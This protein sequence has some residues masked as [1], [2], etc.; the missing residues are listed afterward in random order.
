M[1]KSHLPKGLKG[2]N[3][4]TLILPVKKKIRRIENGDKRKTEFYF[5]SLKTFS[6]DL[7]LLVLPIGGFP[8][9]NGALWL[10]TVSKSLTPL[11]FHLFAQDLALT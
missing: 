6:P 11:R 2:L 1:I 5:S 10:S 7:V 8:P 4:R 3:R 9:R